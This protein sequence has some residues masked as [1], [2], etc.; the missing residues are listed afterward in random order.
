MC[1][2]M[3]G[4]I[5]DCENYGTVG[6]WSSYQACEET[7]TLPLLFCFLVGCVGGSVGRIV[8]YSEEKIK[9]DLKFI[10]EKYGELSTNSI[11]DSHRKYNTIS[12]SAC[13]RL[14]T[15]EYSPILVRWTNG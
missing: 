3:I 7:Y 2:L 13:D 1:V 4:V 6:I 14:G 9:N 10:Y 12:L 11:T 8:K 5:A 15:K